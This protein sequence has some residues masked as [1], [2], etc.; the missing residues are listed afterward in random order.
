MSGILISI[1]PTTTTSTNQKKIFIDQITIFSFH[2]SSSFFALFLLKC[3]VGSTHLSNLSGFHGDHGCD[4]VICML[5]LLLILPLL[6]HL[7]TCSGF[8][9]LWLNQASCVSPTSSVLFCS[10]S[11]P[12]L[13]WKRKALPWSLS[14]F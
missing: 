8:H 12:F 5:V 11:P 2:Y 3:F 10:D 13:I 6:P 4:Y 1:S 14:L 7:H 9:K